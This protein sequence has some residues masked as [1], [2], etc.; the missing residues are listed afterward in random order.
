MQRN[1]Q[2]TTSTKSQALY[3]KKGVGKQSDQTSKAPLLSHDPAKFPYPAMVFLDLKMPAMDGLEVLEKIRTKL[4]IQKLP[5]I[6]F[7]NA[8]VLKDVVRSYTETGFLNARVVELGRYVSSPPEERRLAS[9]DGSGLTRS[10]HFGCGE[11]V[12]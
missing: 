11:R 3:G 8:D 2:T 10:G 5:I 7:S 4:G 9:Q 6:V 12:V 1:Q